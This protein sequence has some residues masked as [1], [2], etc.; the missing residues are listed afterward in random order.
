M[1]SLVA[2]RRDMRVAAN[3]R[4]GEAQDAFLRMQRGL[5]GLRDDERFGPWVY[6]VARSAI[7]DHHRAAARH[8]V[9]EPG[10]T[11]E[12]VGDERAPLS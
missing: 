6:R 4:R 12:D 3:A 10:E 8:D 2:M 11:E 7:A 5:A 9:V 1:E